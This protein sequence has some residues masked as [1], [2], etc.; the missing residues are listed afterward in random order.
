MFSATPRLNVSIFTF[1]VASRS[2]KLNRSHATFFQI[3]YEVRYQEKGAARL[4]QLKAFPI[5]PLD[6]NPTEVE[7]IKNEEFTVTLADRIRWLPLSS[8]VRLRKR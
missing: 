3:T 4:G 7:R 8:L 5:V 6:I 2:V 1:K